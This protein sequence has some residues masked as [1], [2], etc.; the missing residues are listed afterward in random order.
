[1]ALCGPA[2]RTGKRNGAATSVLVR[3]PAG[4]RLWSTTASVTLDRQTD[5]RPQ[6]LLHAHS[7]FE[8]SIIRSEGT[9]VDA[10]EDL[11]PHERE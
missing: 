10:S 3:K 11:V 1:M 4:V 6:H 9:F 2:R 7:F 5:A 8:Q